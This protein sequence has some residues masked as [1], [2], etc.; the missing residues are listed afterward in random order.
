MLS[1]LLWKGK[2]PEE[3]PPMWIIIVAVIAGAALVIL[4]TIVCICK[5]KRHFGKPHQVGDGM[6]PE[7]PYARREKYELSE[8]EARATTKSTKQLIWEKEVVCEDNRQAYK[9]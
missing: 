5:R 2:I 8:V 7:T 4:I 1:F 9:T 6:P 3:D